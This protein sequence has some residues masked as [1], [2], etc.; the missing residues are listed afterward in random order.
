VEKEIENDTAE[1]I[2][3][4]NGRRKKERSIWQRYMRRKNRKSKRK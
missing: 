2:E 3:E 1:E 4:E